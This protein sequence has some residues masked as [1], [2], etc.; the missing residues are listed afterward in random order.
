MSTLASPVEPRTGLRVQDPWLFAIAV[1]TSASLVFL[2]QP[3]VGKLFLPMLGGSPAIWNTT[4]AFF[5]GALLVGYAYAHFLQRA[6]AV[7]RQMTIHL[8]VLALAALTLPLQASQALGAPWEGAP[9]LWLALAL[10]LTIGAP[11][12]VLSATAPLLQ[13]WYA[14][15]AEP[16]PGGRDAYALYAASNLGSLLALAAYP[17]VVE[18]L[19][20]LAAQGISWSL[21]Y[22]AFGLMLVILAIRM[23]PRAERAPVAVEQAAATP[24]RERLIWVLLAAAPSSLLVG[25]TSHLTADVAS[26]PFLWVV[27]LE[28]YLLTFVIAFRLTKPKPGEWLLTGQLVA[29]AAAL[30]LIGDPNSPW[31]QQVAVHLAAFFV[32][33]LVCHRTLADRRPPAA[34][35]TEFY[36]LMS[37]GG[38]L[39]GGFNAFVA[40]VLFNGVWEYAGVLALSLLARPWGKGKWQGRDL[41]YLVMGAA[42][43]SPVLVPQF[44]LPGILRSALMLAP[45]AIA[46]LLRDRGLAVAGLMVL[47]AIA[48]EVQS[49]GRYD[50]RHRSFF[51]VTYLS[52]INAPELGRTRIMVHGTTLHGAQSLTPGG[53]CRPTAY[54]AAPTVIGTV[55]R[56]EQAAR[57][58]MRIGAVGLGAGTVASFVRPSDTMRFFEIDQEVVDLALDPDRFTFVRGCARGPVDVVVGD[59]RV[60]LGKEADGAF[61]LLL[62][63]AFSSDSVPTHLLTVEAL[64]G[65]LRVT[66]PD[67]A[68][69]LH[70]SNRNLALLG[71]AA[72]AAREAGARVLGGEHWVDPSVSHYVETG[73]QVLLVSRDQAVLDR[74]RDNPE[75]TTPKVGA[76]AW[77]D[78]YTNVWGAMIGRFRGE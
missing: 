30:L 27:P 40:P 49:F 9:A 25:V 2:V 1:F 62:V 50:E 37:L 39:G 53:R 72:A 5:Q 67:G 54:Y 61:D 38:V 26:V 19:M 16:R 34:R 35:L 28:L 68:I 46:L 23:W 20:G 48:G 64:R 22:G 58:A 57:P 51:G 76:R 31:P 70:L 52:D 41:G 74:Y 15:F 29:V 43:I 42:W 33:A 17:I 63:D 6:G 11:F 44:V 59:A 36:L 7:R 65:Y 8:C 14:R 47:V 60:S 75:W 12:A 18:P 4:L 66:P 55:F 10:A 73:G 21:A 24:W 77:T 13:A 69:L 45:V 3:L 32:T 78:D 56:T 71:P